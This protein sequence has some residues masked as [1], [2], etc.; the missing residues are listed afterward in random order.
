MSVDIELCIDVI[1]NSSL[2]RRSPGINWANVD[3]EARLQYANRMKANLDSIAIPFHSLLHGNNCC[4]SFEH[5]FCIEEYYHSIVNAIS[6]ADK[7]LPR[8]KP[9]ISKD[10]WNADLTNLKAAS[11][12]A[13]NVWRDAGKPSSG[14]IFNLKKS[15]NSRYKLAARKAK[16][17]F[18][19][20]RSDSIHND[21]VNKN[22]TKF[23]KSWQELHGK[24]GDVSARINGKIDDT[25]IANEF[26][27]N[28]REIYDEA[29]SD[30]AKRLS[31]DF[32]S[33]YTTC[34]K[35]I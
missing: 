13:F 26:A 18:D 25:D 33:L 3:E 31:D 19:Q 35:S 32:E 14:P 23:W 21:L 7:L 34:C 4:D 8:S 16:K 5:I 9:G 28:F 22:S 11:F 20:G 12:D 15:A 30:Q 6:D 1:D 27:T 29:N 10:Y 17:T 2:N 24:R